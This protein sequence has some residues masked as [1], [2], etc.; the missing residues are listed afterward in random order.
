MNDDAK[1]T[2]LELSRPIEAHGET[3]HQIT[4]REPAVKDL[5]AM[6]AVDG[7]IA[8]GVVLLAQVARIPP[9]SVEAMLATDFTRASEALADFLTAPPP[10]G[11]TSSET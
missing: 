7:D 3:I 1:E 9:S 2:V 10:T 11:G 8:K 6:D 5:K 4:I